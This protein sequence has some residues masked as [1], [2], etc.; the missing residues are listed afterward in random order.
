MRRPLKLFALTV[1]STLLLASPAMAAKPTLPPD[2]SVL[3]S[4]TAK[5]ETVDAESIREIREIDAQ[6]VQ[7]PVGEN[8]PVDMELRFELAP[9][10]GVVPCF[11]IMIRE[12]AWID[13]GD[14][15]YRFEVAGPN[16]LPAVIQLLR[17]ADGQ[18]EDFTDQLASASGRL[19]FLADAKVWSLSLEL[20]GIV[21]PSMDA[22]PDHELIGAVAGSL[23]LG[24]DLLP[25]VIREGGARFDG[26]ALQLSIESSIEELGGGEIRERVESAYL[27]SGLEPLDANGTPLPIAIRYELHP[28][29]TV[30]P[31][32]LRLIPARAWQVDGG[33]GFKL[34]A[35]GEDLPAVF[36][37]L[38]VE[39]G[40]LAD[41]LT[42]H[43]ESVEAHLAF[44]ANAKAWLLTIE[45]TSDQIIGPMYHPMLG[46]NTVSLD[47]GGSLVEAGIR[48]GEAKF[49]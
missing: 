48:E 24:E 23:K 37:I 38:K 3:L 16:D 6:F 41:D 11:I 4:A 19:T 12:A 46:A 2:A 34:E 7:N 32:F 28:T 47:A 27:F 30:T 15:G 33:G 5:I 1:L 13:W 10:Q 42:G 25:A 43:I 26:A 39:D 45:L 40:Q 17:V 21:T 18:V 29:G 9:T 8:G 31:C 20:N 36:K 22:A 35:S 14:A 49:F 44:D